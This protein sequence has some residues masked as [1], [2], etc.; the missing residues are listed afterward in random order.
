[1]K[2]CVVALDIKDHLEQVVFPSLL[3][4]FP[5]LKLSKQCLLAH[6]PPHPG[7]VTKTQRTPVPPGLVFYLG[8]SLYVV[9]HMVF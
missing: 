5:T 1:M 7:K 8:T 4:L 9:L 2:S 3:L 6:L